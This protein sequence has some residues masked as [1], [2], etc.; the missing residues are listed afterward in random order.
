MLGIFGSVC[1]DSFHAALAWGDSR[2]VCS[3]KCLCVLP[4]IEIL[5]VDFGFS[6]VES[7]QARTLLTTSITNACFAQ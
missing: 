7:F 6:R 2:T 4:T 5:D 3:S 1:F